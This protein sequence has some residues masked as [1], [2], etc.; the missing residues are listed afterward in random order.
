MGR[1]DDLVSAEF[2][3][4]E[5]RGRGWRV[6][7]EPVQPEPAFEEFAGYRLATAQAQTDDSRHPGLLASLF[8]ALVERPNAL[9]ATTPEE[10]VQ[11]EPVGSTQPLVAEF[12]ASLPASLDV[13]DSTL[14][15][16]LDSLH[17]CAES[18][19]FE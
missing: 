6:W 1:I 13:S 17:V 19:S 18:T 12:V 14:G 2:A 10:S 7:P 5:Q 8:D 16:F 15:A 11:P 4:W 3:M 9:P